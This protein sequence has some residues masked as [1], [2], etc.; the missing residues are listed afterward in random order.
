MCRFWEFWDGRDVLVSNRRA[1]IIEIE[2]SKFADFEHKNYLTESGVDQD[3]SFE[4]EKSMKISCA[5]F[6]EV[7]WGS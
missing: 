4:Q 3:F 5:E 6:N 7:P 2:P 1:L